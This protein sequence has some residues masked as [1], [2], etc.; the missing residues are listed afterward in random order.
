MG[1]GE[2]GAER[3]CFQK[4]RPCCVTLGTPSPSLSLLFLVCSVS[5]W[6]WVRLC[7]S[8]SLSP[9]LPFL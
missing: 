2:G 5:T 1:P 8:L 6:T 3:G 9:S 7:P 4:L